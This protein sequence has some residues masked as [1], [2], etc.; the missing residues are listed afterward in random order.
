MSA[1]VRDEAGRGDGEWRAGQGGFI[2][3]WGVRASG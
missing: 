1:K 3:A 2:C